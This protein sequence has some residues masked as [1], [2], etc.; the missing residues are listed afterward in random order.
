MKRRD[1]LIRAG[2][3]A[4][5]VAATLPSPAIAQG[6]RKLTLVTDWPENIPGLLS[7][8]RNFARTIGEASK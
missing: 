1:V 8:A 5:G 7:G 3:I 6:T 4:A 2:S